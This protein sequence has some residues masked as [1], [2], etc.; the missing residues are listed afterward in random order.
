MGNSMVVPQKIKTKL[1]HDQASGYIPVRFESR[2]QRDMCA[3][4]FVE[5]LFMTPNKWK[6]P[7]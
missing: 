5:A 1:Q 3:S 4:M 2:S 6:S 7:E